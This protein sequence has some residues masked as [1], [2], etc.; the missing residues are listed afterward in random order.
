MP[1]E[2]NIGVLMFVRNR[3]PF[4]LYKK[5]LSIG[6]GY[7]NFGEFLFHALG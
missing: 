5:P 2:G 7:V 3:P 4:N 6:W 1:S